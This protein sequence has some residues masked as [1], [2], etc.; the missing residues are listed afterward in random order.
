MAVHEIALRTSTECFEAQ[1]D[2]AEVALDVSPALC[3]KLFSGDHVTIRTSDGDVWIGTV[4][5][6]DSFAG[7]ILIELA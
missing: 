7:E 6:S 1:I 2:N 4:I 5:D 3:C